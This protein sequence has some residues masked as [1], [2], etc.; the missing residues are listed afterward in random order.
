MRIEKR[1][2]KIKHNSPLYGYWKSELRRELASGRRKRSES[3]RSANQC[4]FIENFKLN[5]LV[6][7]DSSIR[8]NKIMLNHQCRH[9]MTWTTTCIDIR[10]VRIH[11][12]SQTILKQRKSVTTTMTPTLKLN[13]PYNYISFY[14]TISK[15]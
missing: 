4:P 11:K 12:P 8:G 1:L 10:G 13:P 6:R 14:F 2:K 9:Y 5:V 15:S 3:G 7:T